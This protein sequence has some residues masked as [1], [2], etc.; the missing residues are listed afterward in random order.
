VCIAATLA[1][2]W[3]HAT[4]LT[5]AGAL[6]RDEAGVVQLGTLPRLSEMWKM[7]NGYDSFPVLFPSTIRLWSAIG[8]GRND[9]GLRCLGLLVGVAVLGGLWLNARILGFSRPLLSLALL[10]VNLTLV[11]WGDS[12]RPYGLGCL[13]VLLT[14]GSIWS[15][16]KAPTRGRFAVA[17]AAAVLAVQCFYQGAF[18]VLAICSAAAA[19]CFRCRQGK[20]ALGTLSAGVPAAVS[21]L[22]YVGK[23]L[24]GQDWGVVERTGFNGALACSNLWSALGDPMSWQGLAWIALSYAA[25]ARGLSHLQRKGGRKPIGP[26]ELPLFGSLVIVFSVVSFFLALLIAK[27]PTQPWYWLPLMPPVA[28]CVDGALAGSLGSYRIWRPALAVTLICVP[29]PAGVK[30]ARYRQT[31]IDLAAAQV[32]QA[33]KSND[34]VVVYPWY[35]GI[36]FN[37]YYKGPAPWTTLPALSDLRFH[38]YDLVKESL[39]SQ[40]PIQ[41]V[42]DRMGQTLSSG[43]SVWIVGKLPE[44]QFG[45]TQPP[46]L[47]PAPGSQWGWYDVPYIHVWGRQA[48]HFLALHALRRSLV[49][50]DSG[51]EVSRY[52]NA[53]VTVAWGWSPAPGG[54]EP[55]G[56]Q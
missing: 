46:D 27:L 52:E 26:E 1:A 38:R 53:P 43:N 49:A 51:A 10:G 47:P 15:L 4:Y 20:A 41:A 39:A 11:R 3:L 45:E 2:I 25:L 31:N 22:P 21:L 30:L 23:I 13:L 42:L 18:L 14:L 12:L 54:G 34:L 55:A 37:R 7:V 28:V 9:L 17:A 6:W 24:G 35:F 56:H 8:L 16:A 44:A 40:A 32:W 50:T 48:E 29:L 19:V 36:S 33:A 5:H